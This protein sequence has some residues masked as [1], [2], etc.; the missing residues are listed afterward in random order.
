MIT[1][2]Y[3]HTQHAPL[4]LILYGSALASIA[5]GWMVGETPGL[6]IA[7]SVGLLIASLATCFHHLTVRD[8]G[9]VLAIRFGPVPMSRRSVRY[10]DIKSVEAKPEATDSCEEID[11]R[12]RK[13]VSSGWPNQWSLLKQCR[14]AVFRSSPRFKKGDHQRVD[15]LTTIMGPIFNPLPKLAGNTTD[16]KLIFHLHSFE[17]LGISD[18]TISA[19]PRTSNHRCVGLNAIAEIAP[20]SRDDRRTA[21]GHLNQ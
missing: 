5:L 18:I 15:I 4:C 7:V 1:P 14:M 16:A 8:Q 12:K 17:T 9:E 20:I 2:R 10:P 13:S 6:Y 3:S 21:E 19:I 11:E